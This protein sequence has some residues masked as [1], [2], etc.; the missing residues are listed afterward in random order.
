MLVAMESSFNYGQAFVDIALTPTRHKRGNTARPRRS[1]PQGDDWQGIRL[2]IAM[3]QTSSNPS[4][5][6]EKRW[7]M[8]SP[9][10]S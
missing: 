5:H 6:Q 9:Y 1:S 7:Q 4:F 2:R 3:V 8:V 10:N